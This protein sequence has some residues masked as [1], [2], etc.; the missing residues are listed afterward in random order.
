MGR[1]SHPHGQ[2]G[3]KDAVETPLPSLL[4]QLLFTSRE[5]GS[6][7]LPTSLSSTPSLKLKRDGKRG[8][9]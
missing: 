7:S 9:G 2:R 8:N 4:Q 3:Q 1:H 5:T 6:L